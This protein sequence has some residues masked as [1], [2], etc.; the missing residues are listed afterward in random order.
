M[1]KALLIV[2]QPFEAYQKIV[3]HFRPFEPAVQSISPNASV[4]KTSYL[5]PGVFVGNHVQI[6]KRCDDSSQCNHHGSLHHW[7]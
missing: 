1:G 3:Q 5:Y 4:G 2:D 7:Q 6:G